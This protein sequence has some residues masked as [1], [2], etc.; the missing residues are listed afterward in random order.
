MTLELMTTKKW[1]ERTLAPARARV[2]RLP[3][4]DTIERIRQ[5]AI[6]V[7]SRANGRYAA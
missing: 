7:P 2:K 3:S 1:L 4:A 5:R 6:G